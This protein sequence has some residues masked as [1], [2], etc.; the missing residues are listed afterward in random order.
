[1]N[2][3]PWMTFI[4]RTVQ[5]CWTPVQS[6]QKAAP[7]TKAALLGSMWTFPSAQKLIRIP[8]TAADTALWKSPPLRVT[9]WTA[10][11]WKFHSPMRVSKSRGRSWTEQIQ[12]CA[13]PLI[14]PNRTSPTA[15]NCPVQSWKSVLQTAIWWRAGPPQKRR[16]PCEVWSWEK[17]TP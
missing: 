13:P 3:T 14:F 1:M 2:S 8:A 16:T 10:P 12:I 17:R 11:L 6:W 9:C 5:S 7:P 4:P 15:R